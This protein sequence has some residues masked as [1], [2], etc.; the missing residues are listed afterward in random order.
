MV[1]TDIFTAYYNAA[2]HYAALITPYALH[3]LWMLG[4]I[5]TVTIGI[6]HVMDHD[7]AATLIWRIVRLVFTYFF[8]LWWIENSWYLGLEVLGSFD[9]LGRDITG[10]PGLTPMVFITSATQLAKMLWASPSS[11]RLIPN[12]ALALGEILMA[13]LIYIIFIIV[14]GLALFTIIAGY[15]LLAGGPIIVAMFP[16]RWLAPLTEG[17][18]TWL[19]RTGVVILFFYLVLGIAQTFVANWVTSLTAICAPATGFLPSPLLGAAPV[20]T[21]ALVCANPIPADTL[22]TLLAD[23]LLLAIVSIGIPFIG[24]ALVS[25]G[26]N[27]ALEHLAAAGYLASL[28]AR[29]GH[30]VGKAAVAAAKGVSGHSSNTS[31]NALANRISAGADAA[32]ATSGGGGGMGSSSSGGGGGGAPGGGGGGGSGGAA[33]VYSGSSGSSRVSSSPGATSSGNQPVANVQPSRPGV[34]TK[35]LAVDISHL[36][37]TKPLDS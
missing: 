13:I 30:G 32:A 11:A 28:G 5:E 31:Q 18:F 23:A 3:L 25:H 8:A 1:P 36:Q 7:D 12:I 9:Q 26:V 22:L 15:L 29:A 35:T 34:N 14:A 4:F 33:T 20:A 37:D 16:I 24:G 19:M 2:Q 27:M 10:Q 17:Y 21:P 6:T